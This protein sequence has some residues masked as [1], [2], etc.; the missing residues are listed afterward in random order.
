MEV[1]KPKGSEVRFKM[2]RRCDEQEE[3]KKKPKEQS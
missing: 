3:M 2:Q 1:E